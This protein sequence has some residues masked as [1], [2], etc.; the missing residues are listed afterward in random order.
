MPKKKTDP[1]IT[2]TCSRHGQQEFS[3]FG[4]AAIT[5]K[6]GCRWIKEGAELHFEPLPKQQRE[7]RHMWAKP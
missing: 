1:T 4:F 6:C 5:L 2:F 3:H 7:G